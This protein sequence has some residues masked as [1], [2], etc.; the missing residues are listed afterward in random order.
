MSEITNKVGLR[1][2]SYRQQKKYSQEKLAGIL[3]VSKP[4][5]SS[6]ENG[7]KNPSV[8]VLKKILDALEIDI[9]DFF[10]DN[11]KEE[12]LYAEYRDYF[13]EKLF[14]NSEKWYLPSSGLWDERYMVEMEGLLTKERNKKEC[15]I[16]KRYINKKNKK[17]LDAPCGYGRISNLLVSNGYN[18]TGVD[19]NSYFIDIAKTEAEKNNLKVKYITE[20]IFNFNEKNKYDVVLNIFTSMGYFES[21][22]KNELFIKKLCEFL[23]IGGILIIETVNPFG[24]LKNYKNKEFFVTNNDTKIFQERF[25]DY[26]TSTNIER[27]TDKYSDGRIFKGLHRVRLYYPHEIIKICQKYG[28]RNL[29]ILDGD[30]K[31]KNILNSMRMWLIFQK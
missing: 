12:F 22:E 8:N 26:R 2:K 27:I 18:V 7:K 19:V 14:K 30:G 21:D 6:I 13:I 25:F 29:D 23:K 16:I 1:I 5:I 31:R 11:L 24:I 15:R 20:D 4:Y 28:L 17:I 10:N 3:N 9:F